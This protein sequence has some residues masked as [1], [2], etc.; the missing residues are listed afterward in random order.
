MPFGT[1]SSIGEGLLPR[2]FP[3]LEGHRLKGSPKIRGGL[4]EQAFD[5]LKVLEVCTMPSAEGSFN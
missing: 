3:N 4:W 1:K 2:A 5:G